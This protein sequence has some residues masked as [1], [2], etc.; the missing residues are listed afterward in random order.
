M[1]SRPQ[2]DSCIAMARPSMALDLRLEPIFE[3]LSLSQPVSLEQTPAGV[4]LLAEQGGRVLTFSGNGVVESQNVS[5]NFVDID[6]PDRNRSIGTG[7]A[8]RFRIQRTESYTVSI[9][10]DVFSRISRVHSKMG[11]GS[12][13]WPV[14][15]SCWNWHNPT[16]I[17]MVTSLLAQTG[18]STTEARPATL[19]DTVKTPFPS[20]VPG[21]VSILTNNRSMP[22]QATTPSPMDNTAAQRFFAYGF[23]NVWRFSFDSETNTLWAGD[24]GQYNAEDRA[25]AET[26]AGTSS[27]EMNAT[28]VLRHSWL[29]RPF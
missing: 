11:V 28:Q 10:G 21:P 4:W 19:W 26:T 3:E 25:W 15:R 13:I 6:N 1:E 24:V 16:V 12:S 14:K 20:T 29:I 5:L 7:P 17:T 8:S 18:F 22:F 23:C 27:K 9:N 2:N